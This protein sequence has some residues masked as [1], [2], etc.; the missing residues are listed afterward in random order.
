M[1]LLGFEVWASLGAALVVVLGGVLAWF[2]GKAQ[3]R[4]DQKQQQAQASLNKSEEMRDANASVDR[5][6]R[7]TVDRLRNSGF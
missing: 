2:G 6:R 3:G 5:S 1:G 7:G 4:Q